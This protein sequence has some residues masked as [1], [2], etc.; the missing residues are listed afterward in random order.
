MP[1]PSSS[2]DIATF[3]LRIS[4]TLILSPFFYSSTYTSTLLPSLSF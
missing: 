4:M 3:N 1:Q 2:F